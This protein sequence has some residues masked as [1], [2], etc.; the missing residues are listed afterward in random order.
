MNQTLQQ[1]IQ[2]DFV[3]LELLITALTHSSASSE[4]NERLEYLGDAILN[5]IIAEL[6]F[7]KFP[8]SREGE[9]SRWRASLVSGEALAQLARQF[10]L[11]KYLKLGP[12]EINTGG[13]DRKSILSCAIEAIIGAIYLDSDY[14]SIKKVIQIWYQDLLES[15]NELEK[16]KDSK[17]K[18]QEF[19]QAKHLELPNY[20]ISE[21]TG[22][23]H[24]RNFKVTCKVLNFTTEAAGSSRRQAEQVAAELMLNKLKKSNKKEVK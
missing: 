2:Y 22:E 17:T 18:L 8:K 11:G 12:G 21:I 14:S 4:N 24:Q 6:L 3:N 16:H 23:A 1:K 5:A 13:A 9:L 20:A 19:L 15:L 7:N 10:D